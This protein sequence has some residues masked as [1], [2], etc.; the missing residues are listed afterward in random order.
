MPKAKK[1]TPKFNIAYIA[2]RQ[3]LH[4]LREVDKRREGRELQ[5]RR[6]RVAQNARQWQVS[7]ARAPRRTSFIRG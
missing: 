3:V 4:V 7:N 2:R 1:A 5:W 6:A